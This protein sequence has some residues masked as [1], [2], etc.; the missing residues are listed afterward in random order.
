M[1][2]KLIVFVLCSMLLG[3]SSDQAVITE[4]GTKEQENTKELFQF[5]DETGETGKI[6]VDYNE[7]DMQKVDALELPWEEPLPYFELTEKMKTDFFAF[8]FAYECEEFPASVE[9]Y[10]IVAMGIS[11]DEEKLFDVALG[12]IDTESPIRLYI[13]AIV[14][15]GSVELSFQDN[16]T[17]MWESGVFTES[18][19]FFVEFD[20]LH[21]DKPILYIHA[22]KTGEENFKMGVWNFLYVHRDYVN[23]HADEFTYLQT[24]SSS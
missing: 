14:E 16:E 2:K 23:S 19:Q 17:V 6:V 13:M 3:C 12:P 20:E 4:S 24:D 7:T 10:A 18:S 22:K 15:E 11:P 5:E 9:R 8:P 1:K 21:M